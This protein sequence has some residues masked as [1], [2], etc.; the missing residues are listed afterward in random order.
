MERY[1]IM[2]G[3]AISHYKIIDKIGEGGMGIVY[4]A[5]DTKLKRSVAL[6]FLTP[7]FTRDNDAK[8]RFYNEAQAAAVLSHNNIVTVHE[9]D[10]YDNQI[11]IATEYIEGQNLKEKIESGP[12]KIDEVLKISIQIAEGLQEAHDKDIVH[13]DIKSANIMIT[14]KGQV[15]IMDFGL[16]RLK[17]QSKLTK[18]GTTVGTTAYMSPEQAMGKKVNHRTDIWSLGVVMYE[19][20]TGELPFKGDYEQ[21]IIYAIINEKIRPLKEIRPE[22]PAELSQLIEKSLAK[23]PDQRFQNINLMLQE[24]KAMKDMAASQVIMPDQKPIQKK[25]RLMLPTMIF[26]VILSFLI[27]GYLLFKSKPSGEEPGV[28][29]TIESTW[30]NSI[31]VLPLMDLSANKDQ[32]YF[33]DGMTDAII[34]RLTQIKSLKI[35]ALTSVIRYKQRDKDIKTIG[36]ELGV[37]HIV[38]GT[39]QK[40]DNRVRVRIQLIKAETGFHIWSKSYD[41]TL[42]SIFDI[43]DEISLGVARALETNLIPENLNLLKSSQ[44]KNLEAYEYYRKGLF[45]INSR[46]FIFGQEEDYKTALKMF[47]KALEIDPEYG[48]AYAGLSY[49]YYSHSVYR[50]NIADRQKAKEYAK[51][52]FKLNPEHP[53]VLIQMGM[54]YWLNQDLENAFKAYKKA[55]FLN[56]NNFLVNW[57]VG[58]LFYRI[59]L[60]KKANKFMSIAIELDPSFA[61]AYYWRGRIFLYDFNK[62][63]QAETDL[64]KS[65]ELKKNFISA[66]WNLF[67]LSIIKKN[68]NRANKILSELET[69]TQEDLSPRKALIMASEGKK[70]EALKTLKKPDLYVYCLLDMRD[71]AIG[72]IKENINNGKS[73]SY[74]SLLNNPF[75]Q[76]LRKDHLFKEILANE[77]EKYDELLVKFGDL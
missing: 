77:K 47:E 67:H 19:M 25:T 63:K 21:A 16:A 22:F 76:N 6:K 53:H 26:A 40:E 54:V 11:F 35:T 37:N 8:E 48:L 23:N 64:K 14:E 75:Y 36:H 9:I 73:Y 59:G 50:S 24:L 56:P 57:T 42:E 41:K 4:K 69:L 17:G 51:K 1:Q 32:E 5:E 66:R 34:D 28:K 74:L 55:L 65:I 29:T 18:A 49:S 31:A 33:C 62:L 12:I 2:I 45:Y 58:Y 27:G 7:E 3:K 71:E 52:A 10:E 44:P 72:L 30:T 13:R 46:F 70:Q 61:H 15:K 39:I 20:A 38:E 68:Y 60:S 43:Q